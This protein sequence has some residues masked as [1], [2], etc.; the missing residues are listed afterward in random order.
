MVKG[1][2][3]TAPFESH[4]CTTTVCVPAGSTNEVLIA[5][6]LELN[7]A[8]LSIY[9]RM[10]VIGFA[11]FAAAVNFTGDA[12]VLPEPGEHTVTPV[13]FAVQLAGD[14]VP[15]RSAISAVVAAAPG[16]V[17]TPMASRAV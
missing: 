5:L 10:V 17:V 11:D 15:N 8:T 1:V 16:Y 13:V 7:F 14:A 6:L 3:K 2:L 4:A 12:T 9:T